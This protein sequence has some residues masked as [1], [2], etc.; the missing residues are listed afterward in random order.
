M[1][2]INFTKMQG[3]G[4][5]FIVIDDRLSQVH[6]SKQ[7]VVNICDR[8]FGIGADGVMIIRPAD[9]SEADFS[10]WFV[11]SDGSIPEMCG[12]GSR[13]FARY[14]YEHDLLS[15]GAHSFVLETLSGLKNIEIITNDDAT[16]KAARVNMGIAKSH[17]AAVPTTLEN[18]AEGTAIGLQLK[19]AIGKD[20]IVN[21]VNVGNPHTILFT[22][23]NNDIEGDENFYKLGCAIENDSHFPEKTNVE[24]IDII[25]NSTISMRVWERGCGETLACGTGA[26]AS[27]F[28][29]H[30]TNRTGSDVAVHLAGGDLRIEITEKCELFMTGSAENVFEGSFDAS[31]FTK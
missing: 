25:D 30:L 8:R 7:Q 2:K 23:E 19:T 9:T 12:N 22:D 4:N 29:A 1:N 10:W 6:L 11:N 20:V 21:C 26:C 28:A 13:C 24:F 31:M 27:A 3:I 18:N 15:E 17:T 16:F 14:V 5:D